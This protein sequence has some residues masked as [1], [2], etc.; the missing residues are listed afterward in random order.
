MSFLVKIFIIWIIFISANF[1]DETKIFISLAKLIEKI[2][3]QI[4]KIL[5]RI[6]IK[7][8]LKINC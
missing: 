1:G 2:A 4:I 5:I 7:Y 8:F 3:D 6:F